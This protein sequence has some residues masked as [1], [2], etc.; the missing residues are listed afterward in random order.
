MPTSCIP[1]RY[2]GSAKTNAASV[3]LAHNHPSGDNEPSEDDI[4]D[5]KKN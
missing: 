1:G 5:N 4:P 2:L 3:I